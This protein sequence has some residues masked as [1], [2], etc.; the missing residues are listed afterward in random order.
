MDNLNIIIADEDGEEIGSLKIPFDLDL[1]IGGENDYQLTT[2]LSDWQRAGYKIGYQFFVPGTE[3][4]GILQNM[5]VQEGDDSV[6]FTGDTWRGMMSDKISTIQNL[7]EART[8]HAD[9]WHDLNSPD[10]AAAMEDIRNTTKSDI[11]LY[12]PGGKV[13]RS[14]TPEIFEKMIEIRFGSIIILEPVVAQPPV[15]LDSIVFLRTGSQHG[16]RLEKGCGL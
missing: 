9:D 8:R 11:T 16:K 13:F 15:I 10:I 5:Q 12:T 6:I 14:T 1:D 7:M 4:G 2:A 3:Y